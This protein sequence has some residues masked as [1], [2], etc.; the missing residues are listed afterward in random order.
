MATI[1]QIADKAGVS[2]TTVSR[3][4]NNDPTMSIS[5]EKK[6]I[7]FRIT[8]ELNYKTPRKRNKT[9]DLKHSFGVISLNDELN[10]PYYL[11]IR[12]SIERYGRLKNITIIN[13]NIDDIE[14]FS[15][16]DFSGIIIVGFL[17]DHRIRQVKRIT[18]KIVCVDYS[19]S[20]FEVDVV[21]IDSKEAV[22][23]VLDYLTIKKKYQKIGF[24]GAYSDSQTGPVDFREQ[25]LLEYHQHK[26]VLD[27]NH[28]Y[29]GEFTFES[30]Y[31]I[32]KTAIE[33]GNLPKAF[34]ISNDSIAIGAIKAI[35]EAGLHIPDDI[36]I[37]GFNDIAQATYVDPPLSTL[38]LNPTLMGET[39]ID[40]LLE[41]LEGRETLK[42]VMLSTKLIE[43]KTT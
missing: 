30:G 24:I 17:N 10:D 5:N 7:I 8:D 36:A 18:E 39:S 23:R 43:R 33:K 3:V 38:R 32:M 1:K 29:L 16:N 9:N 42:K 27:E 26:N 37:M 15:K 4:L 41:R 11:S 35:K 31:K 6:E 25:Y 19:P 14:S 40:L 22:Y 2:I 34:F 20:S 21:V 28:K 12:T 13:I